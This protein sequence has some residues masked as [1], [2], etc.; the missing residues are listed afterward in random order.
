MKKFCRFE[1]RENMWWAHTF[2]GSLT[3][4]FAISSSRFPTS[5]FGKE[6]I[7]LLFVP[8]ALQRFVFTITWDSFFHKP[9]GF[10]F[11]SF[12]NGLNLFLILFRS[13]FGGFFC[14]FFIGV[15][16]YFPVVKDFFLNLLFCLYPGLGLAFVSVRSAV[17]H[18]QLNLH[19]HQIEDQN[20]KQDKNWGSQ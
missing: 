19:N 11:F 7:S 2:I 16:A 3:P 14:F 10:W 13:F 8:F 20:K 1:I 5:F 6:K 15:A 17:R 18:L 12:F 4:R 9:F